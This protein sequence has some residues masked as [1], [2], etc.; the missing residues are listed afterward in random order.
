MKG[1]TPPITFQ[2]LNMIVSE[3]LRSST[4]SSVG[5]LTG[6][7]RLRQKFDRDSQVLLFALSSNASDL[8]QTVSQLGLL[9]A[10]SVG[11]LSAP[12]HPDVVSCSVAF[13]DAQK[14]IPFRSDIPGRVP[15]QVGR[16]HSPKRMEEK[17]TASADDSMPLN[18]GIDWEEVWSKGVSTPPL[19]QELRNLESVR[20][21]KNDRK[22]PPDA[23]SSR[24]LTP[25]YTSQTMHLRVS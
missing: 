11:C 12:E 19:P 2:L 6:I 18:F 21:S 15:A 10:N 22:Y 20:S 9:A 16:W 8:S 13:L 7:S 5:I 17:I 1:W 23:S 25:L 24:K 14:V 4:R 3:T